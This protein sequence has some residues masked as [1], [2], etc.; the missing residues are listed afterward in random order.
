MSTLSNN[1]LILVG[2][3]SS[4]GMAIEDVCTAQ[5]IDCHKI[6][7]KEISNFIK[8]EEDNSGPFEKFD[9]LC[10]ELKILASKYKAAN[11]ILTHRV[12][13]K[14]PLEAIKIELA[15][16]K[17]LILF[18]SS[19]FDSLKVTYIGSVTGGLVDRTSEESYH[20][21]KDLQKSISRYLT[22]TNYRIVSNVL[23]LSAF[24]KYSDENSSADYKRLVSKYQS[25][26]GEIKLLEIRRIANEILRFTLLADGFRGCEIP[27][28][29]G[30]SII[31][32]KVI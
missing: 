18:L 23:T 16:S 5:K 8:S 11:V 15:I 1:L 20:F 14:N 29:S 6:S 12:R 4:L 30:Y 9:F 25:K 7:A 3:G 26:L 19:K 22:I 13:I 24:Q 28:D 10:E 31:Q 2:A 21:T 17:D 32:E 27:L